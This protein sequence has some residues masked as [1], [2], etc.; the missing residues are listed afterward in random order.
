MSMKR[1]KP[2]SGGKS[3]DREETDFFA[4]PKEPEK[5]W[6]EQMESVTDDALRPYSLSTKFEKGQFIR[7]P[8]FGNGVV[9]LVEGQRI[10]ILFEDGSKKLG[11][12][13]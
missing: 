1:S 9:T 5:T 4:K 11:H 10:E 13:S 6:S 3:Q 2:R 8:K 7:H 12:A